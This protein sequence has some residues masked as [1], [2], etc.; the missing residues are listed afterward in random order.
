MDE[1]EPKR[2]KEKMCMEIVREV[3]R[4]RRDGKEYKISEMKPLAERFLEAIEY[5]GKESVP[6]IKIVKSCEFITI[7]GAMKDRSMSGFVSIDKGTVDKYNSDKIIG[8]NG[9]D[10]F[11]HQR[12]VIAHEFAHYLFD[13]D[14]SDKPYFDTYIKN[15][16]K[17]IKEQVANTFAANLLMPARYFAL[18]FDENKRMDGNI[19]DWAKHFEVQEKAA[20]KRVLEVIENGI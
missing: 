19:N 7:V 20:A 1:Y 18:R 15:S 17:P 10:E 11:G 5:D 2:R 8:V 14:M 6:I 13:Y 9:N 3:H 16:H 12:F 4:K